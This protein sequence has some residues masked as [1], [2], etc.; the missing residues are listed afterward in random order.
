MIFFDVEESIT[1]K[2]FLYMNH[3]LSALPGL[4]NFTVFSKFYCLLDLFHH[5]NQIVEL[6]INITPRKS[7]A[8]F[9]LEDYFLSTR[10]LFQEINEHKGRSWNKDIGLYNVN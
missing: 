4:P 7:Y 2:E 10:I 9:V 8:S 6:L 3:P 5:A 1:L